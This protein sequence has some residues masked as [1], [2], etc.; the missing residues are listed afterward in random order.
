MLHPGEGA[1]NQ[2]DTTG[3]R[4]GEVINPAEVQNDAFV[5]FIGTIRTPFTTRDLCPR[6]GALDGPDC[7]LEVLP[8]WQAALKGI[9]KFAMLDVLYWLHESRRDLVLQSPKN[10]G[11]TVGTFALRSPVRPN[12]IGLSQ[13]R[14][15][16]VEDGAVIVKGLDCLD[17]TP[18]ID[19]KPNR[20]EYTP[21]APFKAADQA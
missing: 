6:Q 15:I 14:L 3:I 12:P 18:L 19:I 9:E 17:K 20:C 4:S 16:R 2:A 21:E 5:Q 10:T 11:N 7:R 13:V 1:L 8:E